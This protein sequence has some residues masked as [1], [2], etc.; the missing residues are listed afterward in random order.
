MTMAKKLKLFIWRGIL[1]DYTS[2]IAFALAHDVEEARALVMA[3]IGYDSGTAKSDLAA[4]PEV[5]EGPKGGHCWG[6]G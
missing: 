6:G 4:E 1:T 2:G 3:D 5:F